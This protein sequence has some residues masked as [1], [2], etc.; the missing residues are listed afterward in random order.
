MYILRP[1]SSSAD[2]PLFQQLPADGLLFPEKIVGKWIYEA[3]MPEQD[4]IR[5]VGQ[6]YGNPN[7][8][9]LDIGA[10]VGTY[11]LTL[12]HEFKHTYAFECNPTVFCCLAGNVGLRGL[13][14]HIS[15]LPYALG[16]HNGTS[17][18]HVRSEDGGGNG[19]KKL[20]D[21]DDQCTT[22][23]V[24]VWTLDSFE[25]DNIG[26]IK[27]DVEGFEKEVVLGARETLKRSGYP[28]IVFE[29][30]GAW[31]GVPESIRTELFACLNEIGYDI[32]VLTGAQDMFVATVPR[33]EFP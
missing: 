22:L 24:E 25:L 5:W 30:W 7:K 16:N 32:N 1:G 31:K 10:H 18:Y 3:G 9:F 14:T 12:A 29:S 6:T 21:E 13:T 33:S 27:I 8:I 20:S 28:P 11:A 15:P 23:T 17:T 19:I 26:C 2:S 4:L